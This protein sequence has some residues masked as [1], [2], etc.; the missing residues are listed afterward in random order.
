M[1]SLRNFVR[2]LQDFTAVISALPERDQPSFFGLPANIDRS[3][4]RTISSRVISQL[5][6]VMRSET[7]G[8]RFDRTVWSA[9]LN[10]LLSL[11]KKLNQV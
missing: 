4:Q 11:W 5:K 7:S 9:E 6:V 2:L 8:D 3:S 1:T 10:P